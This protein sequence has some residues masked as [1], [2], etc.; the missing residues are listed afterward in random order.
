MAKAPTVAS[1][2]ATRPL[3][4]VCCGLRSKTTGTVRTP[5]EVSTE[6]WRRQNEGRF[7]SWVPVPTSVQ[8]CSANTLDKGCGHREALKWTC[9]YDSWLL[10]RPR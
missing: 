4:L 9:L 5:E 6:L 7:A 8:Q 1:L 2:L 10:S 3:L